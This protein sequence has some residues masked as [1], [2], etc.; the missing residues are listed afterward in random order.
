MKTTKLRKGEYQVI[1]NGITYVIAR[2]EHEDNSSWYVYDSEGDFLFNHKTK[3]K[4]LKVL[5]TI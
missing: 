3:A 5:A 1:L 4:C 2:N